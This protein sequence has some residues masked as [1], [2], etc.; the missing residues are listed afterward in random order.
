MSVRDA[1]PQLEYL[2]DEPLSNENCKKN[3]NVFDDDW[4]YMEKLQQDVSLQEA[5]VT[6]NN[7]EDEEEGKSG[8]E[9]LFILS[10]QEISKSRNLVYLSLS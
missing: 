1:I 9:L 4:A 8:C 3:V 6:N 5:L 10:S 2:D 7:E